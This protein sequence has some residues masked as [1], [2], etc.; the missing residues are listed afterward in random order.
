L[1]EAELSLPPVEE[2]G[3]G[4]G[5]H[6][7]H[8]SELGGLLRVE[9][10]AVGV[11][12][13]EGGNSLLEGN[14]VLFGY[15]EVFIEAAYVDVDQEEV[16]VEEFQVGA[17]V[18]VNVENL[19]V[20]AP[21]A[22][23]IEDDSLVLEAGLFESGGD[24]GFGIG[25]GG[26]EMFLHCG[27][28]GYRLACDW[29][30]GWGWGSGRRV[31]LA[32]EDGSGGSEREERDGCEERG[33]AVRRS[34]RD[35]GVNLP[36][37][38]LEWSGVVDGLPTVEEGGDGFWTGVLEL[39][40]AFGIQK[41]SISIDYCEGG[42][43]FGDGHVVFLR[44][45]DIFVHVTDV[46]VD[47]DEIFGEEFGVGTLAV[48]DVEKLAVAAP[49][50]AKVEENAFVLAAGLGEGGGDVGSGV[51]GLGIEVLVDLIDDLRGGI[52]RGRYS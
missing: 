19:A 31:A 11:E 50:A 52:G 36:L 46:D 44:D 28:W 12:H 48:V 10:F 35:H 42:D 27:H 13:G 4:G 29:G 22:A 15:V 43:A 8:V 7:A 40:F 25:F 20:T 3:D 23:E 37:R 34:V 32:S 49:V 26:I 2:F 41:I 39:L 21:V 47:E 17:L 14:V 6:V 16:L 45:I 33:V 51:G 1:E 30:W 18:E 5:V 9:E 38:L 24:F